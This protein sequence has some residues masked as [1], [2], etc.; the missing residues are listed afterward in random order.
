[1]SDLSLED[2]NW[3]ERQ[4]ELIAVPADLGPNQLKRFAGGIVLQIKPGFPSNGNFHALQGVA[5]G[6]GIGIVGEGTTGYGVRGHSVSNAGVVGRSDSSVGV[7]G[8][9]Q[10]SI[11]VYKVPRP[12]ARGR[13]S[14]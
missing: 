5:G 7:W 3:A 8:D 2:Q 6:W 11:G 4:T 9:V 10:N 1:M 12:T 13:E 14:M